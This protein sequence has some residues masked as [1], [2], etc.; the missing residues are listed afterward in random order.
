M[1]AILLWFDMLMLDT[2][3][4]M[5]DTCEFP[6]YLAK[7]YTKVYKDNDYCKWSPQS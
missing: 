6:I 7:V 4:P 3:P 1:L 5:D 2:T